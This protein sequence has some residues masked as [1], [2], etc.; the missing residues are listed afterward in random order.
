MARA[1]GRNGVV[2]GLQGIQ[3]RGERVYAQDFFLTRQVQGAFNEMF[4]F[5]DIAWPLIDLKQFPD[6]RG[7]ILY[8]GPQAL[9]V[10]FDEMGGQFSDAVQPVPQE[11]V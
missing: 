8:M 6:L 5:P 1:V 4:Q 9:V 11:E 2:H 7:Y 10:F 3:P